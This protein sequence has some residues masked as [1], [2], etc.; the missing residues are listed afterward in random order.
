M[1]YTYEPL[2]MTRKDIRVM[3]LL[4]GQ[5]TS[6]IQCTIRKVNLDTKPEYEALSYE[7]GSPENLKEIMVDGVWALYHLRQETSEVTMWIDA[8][9][10]DQ[11]N[12]LEQ[13]HQVAMMGQVYRS[14]SLV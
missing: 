4:P 11:D 13:S 10:I 2:D 12:I 9:C 8:I 14:A 3:K 1:S 7:W 5:R 6:G